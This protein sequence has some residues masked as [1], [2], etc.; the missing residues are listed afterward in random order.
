M[1][2][3][4][5]AKRRRRETLKLIIYTKHNQYPDTR[6]GPRNIAA[7]PPRPHPYRNRA[8]TSSQL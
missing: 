4:P 8:T 6:R 5:R 3:P 2:V 1:P 7:T